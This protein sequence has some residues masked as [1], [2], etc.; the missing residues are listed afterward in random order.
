VRDPF[1][2]ILSTYN[3]NLLDVE[4]KIH[5]KLL[6]PPVQERLG[7]QSNVFFTCLWEKNT[8]AER[9]VVMARALVYDKAGDVGM[10]YVDI[11]TI[12]HIYETF[13]KLPNALNLCLE[14]LSA[15]LDRAIDQ[16]YNLI[17]PRCSSFRA[18]NDTLNVIKRKCKAGKC[19]A[20]KYNQGMVN[21]RCN[22]LT[23]EGKCG[24]FVEDPVYEDRQIRNVVS[25]CA[26]HTTEC[27]YVTNSFSKKNFPI[28]VYAGPPTSISN[29]SYD[30][31]TRVWKSICDH[32]RTYVAATIDDL[33]KA[34]LTLDPETYYH[35]LSIRQIMRCGVQ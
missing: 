22:F 27:H 23:M 16:I 34:L 3:Y 33:Y 7:C 6:T 2:L 9:L 18:S 1:A 21:Y 26:G 28:R 19:N 11:E 25:W 29:D 10:P 35:I 4:G 31:T 32:H 8:E 12:Y 13:E 24:I 14:D 20:F 17:G 5:I 15:N 30:C